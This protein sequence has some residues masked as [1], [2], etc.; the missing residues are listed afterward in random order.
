MA[1]RG[2]KVHRAIPAGGGPHLPGHHA[3]TLHARLE[4]REHRQVESRDRRV[5]VLD[6]DRR[7]QVEGALAADAGR[8]SASPTLVSRTSTSVSR[9]EIGPSTTTVPTMSPSTG[10]STGSTSARSSRSIGDGP[11]LTWV[12]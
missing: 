2:R 9:E 3:G 7:A 10:S 12:K 4:H 6:A 8:W 11:R 1:D 5:E